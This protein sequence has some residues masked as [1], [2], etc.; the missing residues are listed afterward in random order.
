MWILVTINSEDITR[1][2]YIELEK[3]AEALISFTYLSSA[4]F[5]I[6]YIGRT[7][8]LRLAFHVENKQKMGKK[9]VLLLAPWTVKLLSYYNLCDIAEKAFWICGDLC[10]WRDFSRTWSWCSIGSCVMTR[11]FLSWKFD[12]CI[13]R[14]KFVDAI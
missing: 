8:S 1:L 14:S 2:E 11:E 7:S 10:H 5:T 6:C 12:I 9:T 4:L 3:V 13:G